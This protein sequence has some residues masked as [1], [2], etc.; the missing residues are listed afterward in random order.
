MSSSSTYK[1]IVD[2][3]ANTNQMVKGLDE[4]MKEFVSIENLAKKAG[5]AIG[6]YMAAGQVKD[7]VLESTELAGKTKD[8]KEAFDKLNKPDLLNKLK[9]AT[10]GTTDELTLMQTAVKADKF[11][12]S[13]DQLATYLEFATNTAAETGQSVDYLVDSIITGLG[14]ES[15]LILDNLGISAKALSDRVKEVGN[16]SEA[17]GQI[18]NEMMQKSGS[19]TKNYAQKVEELGANLN[20]IKTQAGN[21]LMPIM[22]GLVDIAND[23]IRVTGTEVKALEEQQIAINA[24]A[25]AAGSLKE[26]TEARKNAIDALKKAYPDY[27][28]N[29]D[30]EKTKNEDIAKALQQVNEDYAKKIVIAQYGEELGKLANQ[31]QK[32]EEKYGQST[33][34]LGEF[35]IGLQEA[36]TSTDSYNRGAMTL[37][38][39][40]KNQE[41]GFTLTAGSIEEMTEKIKQ[42]G[43]YGEKSMGM[44]LSNAILLPEDVRNSIAFLDSYQ[45]K[46]KS[47]T[48]KTDEVNN[49]KEAVLGM[50]NP[51]ASGGGAIGGGTAQLGLIEQI[52]QKIK[53]IQ[54][55]IPTAKNE[56]LLASYNDQLAV[57][58]E[59]L[60]VYQSLSNLIEKITPK[61]AKQV[62]TSRGSMGGTTVGRPTQ[63]ATPAA[64]QGG[65]TPS[66]D[67]IDYWVML[68]DTIADV[69]KKSEAYVEV[70]GAMTDAFANLFAGQKA[71]WKEV[72][73]AALKS[74]QQ[75]INAL[76]AQAIA[77]MIA[78]ESSKGI[79]GLALAAIGVAALIGLWTAFV[80]AFAAGGV[81]SGPTLAMVGEYP[82][83]SSN[84]EVIAPLSK[85][86]D[87]IGGQNVMGGN[88][89][90]EIEGTRLVGVLNNY[91]TQSR[92]Y[93]NR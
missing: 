80:P 13:L 63:L 74:I 50:M 23:I 25:M 84:P 73:T 83:A 51:Q 67:S 75:I 48:D 36:A 79:I 22:E 40:L 30:A 39:V 60:K 82:G 37:Q 93:G 14:R 57:L 38:G 88:V 86:K 55:L 77:G 81:V 19:S 17:A 21:V 56:A 66:E 78:K 64:G 42:L 7:L 90:F 45:N 5:A 8:V 26:G 27:F 43:R 61:A 18:I 4:V 16:F 49:M 33:K 58:N 87:M 91:G 70:V 11:K 29:L 9:I 69:T 85:L 41:E 71:G 2:L 59:Q 20:E 65:L 89:R 92:A 44:G 1:Y 68:G 62:S 15:P 76:L 3:V 32:L 52:Q 24:T 12:I 72:V 31:Q 53:E 47:I 28:G 35:F 54:D 46:L 34:V 10:K 6:T